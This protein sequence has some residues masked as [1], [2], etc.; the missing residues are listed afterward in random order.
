MADLALGRLEPGRVSALGRV[1]HLL[2][3]AFAQP[4]EGVPDEES[5]VGFLVLVNHVN[6]T[7]YFECSVSLD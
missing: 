5:W 1:C 2:L 6:I 4:F 7:V 3:R